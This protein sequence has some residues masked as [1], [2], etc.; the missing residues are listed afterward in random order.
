MFDKRNCTGSHL[1]NASLTYSQRENEAICISISDLSQLKTAE[2]YSPTT[3]AP[4]LPDVNSKLNEYYRAISMYDYAR[5]QL[6]Q[7]II[8]DLEDLKT[9]NNK[10]KEKIDEYL[11]VLANFK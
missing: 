3:Q 2:R 1:Y 4:C 7:S 5:K 8:N 6:F 11:V 10:Y 9:H